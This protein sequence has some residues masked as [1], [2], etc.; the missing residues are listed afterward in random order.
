MNAILSKG[1]LKSNKMF[2]SIKTVLNAFLVKKCS[3]PKPHAISLSA[4]VQ[5]R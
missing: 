4:Q 5:K 3:H 1:S 2:N